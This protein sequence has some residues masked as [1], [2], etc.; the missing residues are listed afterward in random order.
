MRLSPRI[1]RL[2][3]D[4]KAMEKL[5]DESSI[6]D[7]SIPSAM[8]GGP[9]EV[10]VV[11]FHG[12]GLWKPDESNEIVTRELHEVTIKLG[13]SYPRQIPE[14]QWRTPI[15]HPNISGSGVVCLGGYSTHWAPS[16]QLD[17]L[18]EML[19][20]MIR[21]HN[22]DV[23]SPYNRA[24]AVWAKTQKRFQLPVDPRPIRDARICEEDSNNELPHEYLLSDRPA[25]D[26][27]EQSNHA[28]SSNGSTTGA[29]GSDRP[30]SD[31]SFD[32]LV[33]NALR[34]DSSARSIDRSE[35]ADQP[36]DILFLD[37]HE[38][39][40]IVDAEIIEVDGAGNEV[41]PES[42]LIEWL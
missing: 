12:K 36:P 32:S 20:D 26:P 34:N 19:W 4:L 28:S 8:H 35:S 24:A 3:S 31:E 23:E 9:P 13:A 37:G 2:R 25:G 10:Y 42:P 27:A 30:G 21:F 6:L 5:R 1:R 29:I 41:S 40:E 17:E 15:F 38:S 11:R 14:L 18:C 7:F 16:L 33:A 39:E 22:L